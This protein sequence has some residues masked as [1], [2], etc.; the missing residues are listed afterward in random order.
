MD[1]NA[2]SMILCCLLY[3]TSIAMGQVPNEFVHLEW[4]QCHGCIVVAHAGVGIEGLCT[5][6]EKH[7]YN[8]E[9]ERHAH[10]QALRLPSRAQP[11]RCEF[12]IELLETPHEHLFPAGDTPLVYTSVLDLR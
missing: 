7:E 3:C 2:Q 5:K 12:G 6:E 1:M 11:L 10:P 9:L 4:K 8:L